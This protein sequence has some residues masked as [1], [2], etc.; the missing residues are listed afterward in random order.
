MLP[1]LPPSFL[2]RYDLH[3][4]LYTLHHAQENFKKKMQKLKLKREQQELQQQQVALNQQLQQQQQG[5]RQSTGDEATPTATAQFKPSA[6][7]GRT[8]PFRRAPPPPRK[9][10]KREEGGQQASTTATAEGVAAV[11]DS[12]PASSS[13]RRRPTRPAPTPPEGKRRHSSSSGGPARSSQDTPTSPGQQG[14]TPPHQYTNMIVFASNGMVGDSP[15]SGQVDRFGT[16]DSNHSGHHM[17]VDLDISQTDREHFEEGSPVPAVHARSSSDSLV[18][19]QTCSNSLPDLTEDTAA[20]GN[21]ISSSSP[22]GERALGGIHHT[23][24]LSLIHSSKEAAQM[25]VIRKKKRK[26]NGSLKQRSRSPPNLPPPPPPPMENAVTPPM[27][28]IAREQPDGGSDDPSALPNSVNNRGIVRAIA[29]LDQQLEEMSHQ[30]STFKSADPQQQ[31]IGTNSTSFASSNFGPSPVPEE[32]SRFYEDEWLCDSPV[33]AQQGTPSS[34]GV[35]VSPLD[36]DIGP[37]PQQVPDTARYLANGDSVPVSTDSEKLTKAKHRV[38]FKEEVEDIPLYEPHVDLESTSPEEQEEVAAAEEEVPVG[39][40]A[41]KMK[42][43]GKKEQEATRYKKDGILSPKYTHPENMTFSEDYFSSNITYAPQWDTTN[44]STYTSQEDTSTTHSTPV[45]TSSSF[46]QETTAPNI[47]NNNSEG[48]SVANSE[49]ATSTWV[50]PARI[51][52]P[53]DLLPPDPEEPDQN[54]Y[55]APWDQKSVSK[56]KVI[57]VKRR[58]VSPKEKTPPPTAIKKTNKIQYAQVSM[59]EVPKPSATELRNVHSLERSLRGKPASPTTSQQAPPTSQ[60]TDSLLA[61]IND[62]LQ[63]TSRYGSDSFLSNG[64][65]SPSNPLATQG[66]SNSIRRGSGELKT[67]SRGELEK[68]RAAH[69]REPALPQPSA[70]AKSKLVQHSSPHISSAPSSTT[71]LVHTGGIRGIGGGTSGYGGKMGTR[72]MAAS[73]EGLQRRQDTHVTYD[74]QTRAH[75]FRSLV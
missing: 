13:P 74:A 14:T 24:H 68:I 22:R 69:R 27:N 55:D 37:S 58:S 31:Q 20:K 72:G 67:S 17:V 61:S 65:T 44:T 70:L 71:S 28:N 46:P 64:G 63:A 73:V 3:E 16:L 19:M 49:N 33:P 51:S 10:P 35:A 21:N 54:P 45:V 41:I 56:Y 57:G 75:I 34:S 15:E 50:P 4:W 59:E 5:R 1:S 6:T 29:S 30:F 47:N 32:A 9:L 39:V 42:L 48:E 43:F 12:T 25:S 18:L 7:A 52:S 53:A 26:T 62:T 8:P 11:G 36:S 2:S 66:G 60:S 23:R 38:M 40:A